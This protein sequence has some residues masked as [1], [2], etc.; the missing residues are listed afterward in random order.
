MNAETASSDL[1]LVESLLRPEAYPWGPDH[2]ELIETHIS[3][4]FLAGDRVVKVKR[5]VRFPFVD[6]STPERRRHSCEEEVRLNR[7][8]SSGVYLDV[9]GITLTDKGYVVNGPGEPVEW[10]TLMRRLPSDRM[11]DAMLRRGEKPDHLAEWLASRLVPFHR[12]VAGSC[13]GEPY[14][15]AH[16]LAKVL[17]DNLAELEPFAGRFFGGEQLRLTGQAMR[18][19]LVERA[20]LLE[21]RVRDGWVRD[22]HGDLRAEHICVEAPELIQIIDCVEFNPAIRCADVASDLAFLLVD[23]DRLGAASLAQEL[24]AAYRAGGVELPPGLVRLYRA[25][26]ALVRV[27]IHCLTLVS[28]HQQH[29]E[30]PGEIERFLN[31]A[32][33]VALK[34]HPV[35][36][37]MTG[38][39]GTG[40][41]VVAG[42]L[43]DALGA[44]LFSSDAVRKELAGV[45]GHA[46][47]GWEEGIYQREWTERTYQRLMELAGTVLATGQPVILDATF[48]E[49]QYRQLAA[50]VARAAG[51]PLVIVETVCD[52]A[53][54]VERI[55]RRAAQ[56]EAISDATLA[57]YRAQRQRLEEHPPAV[58][59]GAFV[60]RIDTTRDDP[61]RLDAVFAG[62]ARA[63]VIEP[64]LPE[65]ESG[66]RRP[67]SP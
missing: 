64:R 65:N 53:V 5:P 1:L 8:L 55:S 52:E 40:K 3:W 61:G 30:L 27:K 47:A 13:G 18:R 29:P 16:A 46:T 15:Q 26:R 59:E 43:A 45:R 6:H 23:L 60:F 42:T 32:T 21:D 37:I 7:R 25:H 14:G 20:S 44:A 12:D 36:I 35:L 50:Q 57:V 31:Q 62:L 49:S 63:G 41:S 48:L 2:V 38:L 67:A 22:G 58:P 56:A 33:R 17:T 66:L 9:I 11:L 10:A 28:A 54:V 24:L 51:V 19:Y 39:S 34:V 4:V